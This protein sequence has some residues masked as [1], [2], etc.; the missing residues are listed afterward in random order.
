VTNHI[1]T[2]RTAYISVHLISIFLIVCLGSACTTLSKTDDPLAQQSADPLEGF[3]RGM[4]AF[5]G[6]ADKY[7]LRPVASAYSST[8]PKPARIGVSNFFA[9]LGEPLN[10]VNNLLQGK[11]NGALVSTYRFAVNSTVGVLGLIDV[12]KYHNV[13]RKPEDLGQTLAAWGV[14][15]GP[16]LVLPFL[17]P[18]NIRDGAGGL[19]SS[20]VYYPFNEITDDATG[21]IALTVLS[22]VDTR[23]QFLDI[24]QALQAQPDPYLFM[25]SIYETSRLE[26]I[27]DGD[28]PELEDDSDDF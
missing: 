26:A 15:P 24:D 22:A 3:N 10:M 9:N 20:A 13:E 27:Y 2:K 14:K 7:V 28:P 18:S 12:A 11:A 25:K 17:G 21:R 23:S 16:Y 6:T 19:V 5:N 4:F 1:H 8:L